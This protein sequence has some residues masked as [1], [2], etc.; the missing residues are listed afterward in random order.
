[1]VDPPRRDRI[2]RPVPGGAG[3]IAARRNRR[4]ARALRAGGATTDVPVPEC[5]RPTGV[6]AR[7]RTASRPPRPVAA[8]TRE[9]GSTPRLPASLGRVDAEGLELLVEVAAL[10][11]ELARCLRH[12]PAVP[13]E[14][15]PEGGA[16]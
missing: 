4:S 11:P 1:M 2:A 15:V 7:T 5:P 9:R 12:L 8:G 16:L 3:L 6:V 13:L 14:G 10:E